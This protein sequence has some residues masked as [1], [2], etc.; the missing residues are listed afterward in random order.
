MSAS[1]V[2]IALFKMHKTLKNRA[3]GL[4]VAHLMTKQSMQLRDRIFLE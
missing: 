4:N 3:F 2:L 1:N